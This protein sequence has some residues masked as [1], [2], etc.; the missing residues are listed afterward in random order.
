[1]NL[2]QLQQGAA[3]N[4]GGA[5]LYGAATVN[6]ADE[7]VRAIAA[8]NRAAQAAVSSGWVVQLRLDDQTHTGAARVSASISREVHS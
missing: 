6:P 7:L 4:S 5:I 8:L 3:L 2:N 1:M